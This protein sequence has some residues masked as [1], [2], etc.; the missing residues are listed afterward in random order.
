MKKITCLLILSTIFLTGC[1]ST[2][3]GSTSPADLVSKKVFAEYTTNYEMTETFDCLTRWVG[4]KNPFSLRREIDSDGLGG[5][6]FW[7]DK[8]GWANWTFLFQQAKF[9]NANTLDIY[10]SANVA[11]TVGYLKDS[12]SA[13]VADASSWPDADF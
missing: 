1:A 9:G 7:K 4:T 12:A 8:F 13:C 10:R 11:G 3:G 2:L 5:H 6:L